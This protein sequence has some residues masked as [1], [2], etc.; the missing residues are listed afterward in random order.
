[1]QIVT[2][3]IAIMLCLGTLASGRRSATPAGDQRSQ[4]LEP[5]TLREDFQHDSLGQ[6]ASYPPAQD[7]GYEPSLTPVTDHGA[8][9]SRALMRVWKPNRDGPLR[10]GFIRQT[11]LRMNDGA[12]LV[13]AYRLNHAGSADRLEIGLAGADGCRYVKHVQARTNGWTRTELL[14]ADFA[15]ANQQVPRAGTAIE[16]V[17]IVADVKRA[18]ADITYRFLID[19]IEITA[20]REARFEVRQPQTKWIESQNA[21]VSA[22]GLSTGETVSVEVTEPAKLRSVNCT[23][24]DQSETTVST[25]RLFD[26]GTHG[27]ERAGDGRW[28]NSALY[29]PRA[30]DPTGIW[31]LRFRGEAAEGD[32]VATNLRIIYR[33]SRTSS[34]PSLYF[35]AADKETL[36]KRTGDPHTAGIWERILDEAKTRR[37]TGELSQG[38]KAFEL[39]DRGNLL[40]TL[41]AYF[42][43]L[44]RARS[45]IEYNSLVANLTN[46]LEARDSART[47]LLEVA[48]WSRWE[49]PWFTHHGQHTYYPA[50]QLAAAVAFGYDLLYNDLTPA[51]RSL[52]RRA[53]IERQIIPVY[54]EYVLDNRVLANTSNWIGHTVGGALIAAAAI[55][56]DETDD[57]AKSQLEVYLNGL[58]LK[59]ERHLR[60]SYL[61]DGSYGE[62][63]S[64]QEFDLE[65][66]APALVALERVFG[67]DFW[68][69]THVADS[70][71]FPL[72]VLTEPAANSPEMGD[73][74]APTARTIS[75]VAAR[76]K[77][78][79]LNW[80]YGQFPHFSIT[81]FVFYDDKSAVQGPKLPTS[82]IFQ[83][84]GNAV[85]RTGWGKDDA[86]LLFRAGPNF[87]HNHADQGSFL[88]TAFGEQL[89]TEAGWS[90]YY[91]D[92]HYGTYFTQ[93]I[94]HN[95]V[96]VDGNPESQSFPETPQFTA[97]DSYPRITDA[98]T[99]EFYDSVTSD[100]SSVYRD[101]LRRFTRS[102]VF[103]KP[104]YFVVFDELIAN[105][106]PAIFDWLLHLRDRASITTSSGLVLYT[107]A[108]AS[109]AVRTLSPE[110][111]SLDV[112]DGRLPYAIF[113]SAAPK[114]IP[115]QP[116]FL[117]LRTTKSLD[118]TRFLIALVPARTA[119]GARNL[120]S[121]MSRVSG[122]NLVGMRT[123]RGKERDLVIFRTGG[124]RDP[125]V[126]EDWQTDSESLAITE[127]SERMTLF[128]VQNGRS[129][130]SAGRRLFTSDTAASIAA[131]Y[132]EK[133]IEA[134]CVSRVQMKVELFVGRAPRRALV[135]DREAALSYN[136]TA[137]TITITVPSG[138]HRLKIELR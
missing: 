110:G 40:P 18:D 94:G 62:G 112:R 118:S 11:F 106:P 3:M 75:P 73:S 7:V 50:G 52:V 92:P 137:A 132:T 82:R 4:V 109:L 129:L 77:D 25:G 6:F 115:A 35:S 63:V 85:F 19:D 76:T 61:A 80:Y 96:L 93:A 55:A 21:M 49:P 32:Y 111:A 81:D 119:E 70:H 99:S 27:D 47:A 68:K 87:N 58:L 114:S 103:V 69:R 113:A 5:Y 53:L 79:V 33:G 97:L 13:F 44:N 48:R 83:D 102:L 22:R 116:A 23:I 78:P 71:L 37:D 42:D 39:L 14:L 138:E 107:T 130:A 51:E 127:N 125:L 20:A 123:E 41:L 66:T 17:Y 59:M 65:T 104:H 88:L 121:R 108:N 84:K 67:I 31:T 133:T 57:E 8:P 38:A 36:V 34:H 1:M 122:S 105:G 2:M 100:L 90:D 128:A 30:S 64:Y 15:C 89:V 91:K 72:Y 126:F 135:D 56:G 24:Q 74:H 9:G 10:L 136:P 29:A 95:T 98:I 43:V 46:D 28:A 16:A 120:A 117:N 101:R 131:S 54:K 26:D 134:A 124:S 86:V 60:A 12:R 45:R